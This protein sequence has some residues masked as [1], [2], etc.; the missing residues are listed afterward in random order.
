M[1]NRFQRSIPLALAA[2]MTATGWL[3]A[4]DYAAAEAASGDEADRIQPWEE[5]PRYWQYQGEP[6]LLLGGSDQ[7]NPFNHPNLSGHGVEAHL[8]LLAEA[9]G[10]Y[11]RNTMTSRD[12][13]VE[14]NPFF[15]DDNIYPFHQD[16]DTGLYDL[17]RFNDAY[18]ERFRDFLDM[19]A[20]RGIIVQI[21]IWDRVDYARDHADYPAV[22]WSAQPYNPA[23]NI[24]YT[25]AESGLPEVVDTHPG[26]R[27]N[28][29]FRTTP[30]QE[31][32][33][34]VLAYQEAF[35]EELLSISLDYGHVLYCISNETNESEHWSGYWARFI[36]DRAAEAGVGVEITE[37]WDAHDLANP[38]HRHTFDHPDLYSYVDISQNNHQT[39]QTHWDNMQAARELV[40]DPPRPVNSVK[41]Y[42]GE[43]HG[44]GV[45]EGMRKF[46]RNVM[47]GLASAR[48]HR[49][50]RP[51]FTGAGLNELAQTHIRSARMLQD[52]FDI[53]GA[54]PDNGLLAD[55]GPDE[56]YCATLPGEQYAVY[57]T[58]G[59]TAQIDLAESDGAYALRW[60]NILESEW[61][62]EDSVSGGAAVELSAPGD[63]PWAAVLTRQ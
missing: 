50:I 45:E 31:D 7:D 23:N 38:M 34:L 8:D 40:A 9:G 21:E 53:F 42:G 35:V 10:N 55:R 26:Q 16:P 59:G 37:M 43:R 11:I 33:P 39:G 54:E 63:G 57:F 22:G 3:A 15:N 25:A 51:D 56:A 17:E 58:D 2:A 28:P 47:G 29:F 60:L 61:T 30:E 18:W 46:W 24:N 14:D 12:R 4:M 44:G 62:G 27:E 52:T 19:T 48:F 36:R 5:D 32:N 41:I 13:I 6:V 49:P 20:E 1:S